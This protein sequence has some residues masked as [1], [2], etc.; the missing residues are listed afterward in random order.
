M[1]GIVSIIRNDSKNVI[2]DTINSLKKLEYRGYDSSGISFLSNNEI[3]TIKSVGEIDN[4][5]NKFNNDINLQN[6]FSNISISHTRWATHGK[7]TEENAHPH[8]TD[9]VSIVHNGI[10]ENYQSLKIEMMQNGYNFKSTTDTEIIAILIDFYLTKQNLTALQAFEKM[11]SRI[12]G[13]YAIVAIFKDKNEIL[14]AKKNSPL[15]ILKSDNNTIFCISSDPY[16]VLE[17]VKNVYYLKDE[18]YGLIN[19]DKITIFNNIIEKKE[20]DIM[21]V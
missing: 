2:L 16:S 13:S 11:I 15:S 7:V 14:F 21:K 12:I 10:I 17:I 6:V 19:K 4:L 5:L 1:C 20:Q 3:I 9:N 8:Y 18:E